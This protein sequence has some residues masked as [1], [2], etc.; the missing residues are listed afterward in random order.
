MKHVAVG[1]AVCFELMLLTIV[2]IACWPQRS[3]FGGSWK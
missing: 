1:L 2:I 3:P